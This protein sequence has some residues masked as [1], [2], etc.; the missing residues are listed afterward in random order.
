MKNVTEA[1]TDFPLEKAVVL[2]LHFSNDIPD[3]CH[4]VCKESKHGHEQGEDDGTVLRITVQLL[5][6]A[7][8]TQQPNSLQ[9]MNEGHLWWDRATQLGSH[10]HS[11][12][13]FCNSYPTW[14]VSGRKN[15]GGL[16]P[17]DILMCFGSS[18]QCQ[19]KEVP[20]ER[21]K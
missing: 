7:Q 6:E 21:M 10:I 12:A 20:R 9:E 19:E 5:E 11:T 18:D 1:L 8:K 13:F 3:T 15:H 2:P 4:P 16:T 14:K 17:V